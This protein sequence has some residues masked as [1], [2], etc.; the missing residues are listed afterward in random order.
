MINT[1]VHLVRAHLD[2]CISFGHKE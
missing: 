1:I 2:F